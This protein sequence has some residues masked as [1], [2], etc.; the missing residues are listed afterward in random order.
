[1]L[2][3]LQDMNI[4]GKKI[5]LRC[6]FN[7][8]IKDGKILDDN[9]ILQSLETI[10][11]L[12]DHQCKIIILS[13]L[14]KIKKE[15]D[16]VKNSLEPVAK[17]L[18]ELLKTTVIFSKQTRNYMLEEKVNKLASGDVLV[19][20]NTRFEDIPNNLESGND[21]QLASYWASLGDIFV[22][23][24]FGS[25]HRV[26]ASTAGI[27]KYIPSCIG[28][29]VQKELT[30]LNDYVLNPEKPFTIMMGGA[31]I[32]DKL[33]LINKLL[34][35]CDYMLLMGGLANS[36]LKVLG[37]NV[38]NSI[39]ATDDDVLA[40]AKEMLIKYK[41]KISLP[42]DAIVTNDYDEKYIANKSID[43]IESNDIIKDIGSKTIAEYKNIILK[44]MTV[45]TNGTAGVYEDIKFAN[46]T[47][48]IYDI[49]ANSGVNVIVGGGDAVSAVRNFGFEDKFTYISTGGGAT[50]EYIVNE[51]LS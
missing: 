24:A 7:V 35:K 43:K 10:E 19:L 15:S 6:D 12:I 8:P 25:A 21:P 34:P 13:H 28:F 2:K 44:S 41:S 51:S 16:K 50:L 29:L 27:A 5:V 17:R 40:Q 11:Y 42:Y 9:K 48:E 39:V 45:F 30:M 36:C 23:D 46:G 14:G 33:A 22:M 3:N 49:L 38:G 4:T 32:D 26:H 20:E 18:K 1:M 37:F 31:K 47:K